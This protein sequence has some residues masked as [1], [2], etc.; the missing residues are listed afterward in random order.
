M[1]RHPSLYEQVGGEPVLTDVVRRFHERLQTDPTVQHFFPPERTADLIARQRLYFAAI[2]GG[3]ATDVG[4]DLAAAHAAIPIEDH[5]VTTV[6]GHL[7]AALIEAGVSED[8]AERIVA[9]AARLWW[10]RRW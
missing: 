10:A 2:M 3:P 7:R 4:S 8:V 9:V 1:N 5:H 6:V